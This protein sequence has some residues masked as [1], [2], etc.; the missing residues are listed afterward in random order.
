M[1]KNQFQWII[2]FPIFI[3]FEIIIILVWDFDIKIRMILSLMIFIMYALVCA[4]NR[5]D[6]KEK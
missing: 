2:N 1:N 3:L 6:F 5:L 4:A